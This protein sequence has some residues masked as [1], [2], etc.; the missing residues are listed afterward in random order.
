[1]TSNIIYHDF[2]NAHNTHG[3]VLTG[4]ILS[5]GRRKLNT[6]AGINAVLRAVCISLNALC[7]ACSLFTLCWV[8]FGG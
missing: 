1:M 3:L 5:R 6:W 7:I 8:A 2:S 4:D